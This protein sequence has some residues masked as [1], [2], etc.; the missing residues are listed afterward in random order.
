MGAKN[1]SEGIQI[2]I[3]LCNRDDL[4][5]KQQMELVEQSVQNLKAEGAAGSRALASFIRELLECRSPKLLMVVTAAKNIEATPELLEAVE[6]ILSAPLLAPRPPIL[7]FRPDISSAGQVGW[8]ELSSEGIKHNAKH[9]LEVLREKI[10]AQPAARSTDQTEDIQTSRAVNE[11]LET[12]ARC[13]EPTQKWGAFYYS[14]NV[15]TTKKQDWEKTTYISRYKISGPRRVYICDDCVDDK[16][17]WKF[18]AIAIMG[19]AFFGGLIPI[20][21]AANQT[22]QLIGFQ[23][24]CVV[25]PLAGAFWLFSGLDLRREEIRDRLAI[26]AYREDTE[27]RFPAWSRSRYKKRKPPF[28]W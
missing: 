22:W 13:G 25:S 16:R 5:N 18:A 2:L 17:F 3:E 26:R 19:L 6:T 11:V 12:C 10:G 15:T 28:S 14:G 7:S 8:T 21:L 23:C 4:F 24:A 9:A 20:Y 1:K 27:T